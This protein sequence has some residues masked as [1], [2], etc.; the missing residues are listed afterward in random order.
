MMPRAARDLEVLA[1]NLAHRLER[2]GRRRP[3][4]IGDRIVG[5]GPAALRTYQIIDALALHHE[6]ALDIT[7]RRDFLVGRRSEEHTSELQSLMRTSYTVLCLKKTL[8]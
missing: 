4:R 1:Q 2:A 5:T 7:G 8:N 6:R 3:H